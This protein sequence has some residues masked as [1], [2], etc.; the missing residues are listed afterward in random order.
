M[1]KPFFEI[2]NVLASSLE[3]LH[4]NGDKFEKKVPLAIRQEILEPLRNG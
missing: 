1:L 4:L 3:K 2:D